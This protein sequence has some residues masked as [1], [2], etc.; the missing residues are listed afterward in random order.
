ML[1][2]HQLTQLGDHL[3]R[4]AKMAENRIGIFHEDEQDLADAARDAATYMT[5]F[6]LAVEAKRKVLADG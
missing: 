5:K 1:N 4:D 6:Y 2:I 3:E